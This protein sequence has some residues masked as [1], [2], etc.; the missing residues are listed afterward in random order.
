VT[1]ILIHGLESKPAVVLAGNVETNFIYDAERKTLMTGGFI[2]KLGQ[3]K[4]L[5]VAWN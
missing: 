3:G 5:E 4:M 2:L 1:K